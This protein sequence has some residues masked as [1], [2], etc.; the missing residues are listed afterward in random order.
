MI[1]RT[2]LV[3]AVAVVALLGYA[4]SKPND[5]CVARTVRI[6]A[7]P[8]KIVPL[9]DDLQR[10]GAWSPYEKRDPGMQ[11]TFSGPT[12]GPGAVYA[13]AGNQD[14]GSGRMEILATSPERVTIKLDFLA[15]FEGHDT[16]IFAM[17]PRDDA[18]DVTWS[19]H[20]PS[21]FVAKLIG[22]F[23][24]M[25]GMIGADFETGLANLKALAE[26]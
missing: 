10:W 24:D 16:A 15:P 7:P 23:L 4:A 20:G 21:P 3:I 22:V 1:K 8:A 9:V 6:A 26:A 2:L 18:T 13:W 17:D 12:S 25:D 5:F 19:M 14:V 11:R